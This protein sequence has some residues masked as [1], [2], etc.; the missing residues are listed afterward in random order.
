MKVTNLTLN[1]N[2]LMNLFLNMV[3]QELERLLLNSNQQTIIY[4]Q[5][6]DDSNIR[7]SNLYKNQICCPVKLIKTLKNTKSISFQEYAPNNFWTI[8]LKCQI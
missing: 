8:L 5:T 2:A 6:T 3:Q 7:V 4:I 1:C